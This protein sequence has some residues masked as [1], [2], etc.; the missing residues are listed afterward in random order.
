MEIPISV[1]YL[2]VSRIAR[3]SRLLFHGVTILLFLIHFHLHYLPF[4]ID[5]FILKAV[6]GIWATKKR[7]QLRAKNCLTS[8]IYEFHE[9]K[10]F[11][12]QNRE[13]PENKKSQQYTGQFGAVIPLT[14]YKL[15]NVCNAEHYRLQRNSV[16]PQQDAQKSITQ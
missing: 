12:L 6:P 3:Q 14:D 13:N 1:R 2:T 7:G 5:L 4:Y 15:N 8:V 16:F 11:S 10:S 9:P